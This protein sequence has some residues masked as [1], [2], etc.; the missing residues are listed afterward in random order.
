[1]DKMIYMDHGAT[2]PMSMKAFLAMR[3]FLVEEFG[4]PS[5]TYKIG[6][7]AKDAITEARKSVA[8]LIHADPS[9]IYFASGG[10][11]A[12]NWALIKVAEGMMTAGCGNH[13]ITSEIEHGAVLNTCKYLETIG[14]DVTYLPVNEEGLINPDELEN[15]INDKT[16]LVSIMYQNNEIGTI[17]P[18]KA[19]GEICNRH[20]IPFHT[21]AVQAV[22]HIPINVKKLHIDLLSASAHKLNGPKGVGFLYYNH[23]S[24]I[25]MNPLIM[26]GHQMDGLRAGTENV[27]GIVGFGEAAKLSAR[28]MRDNAKKCLELRSYLGEKLLTIPNSH[29]NGVDIFDKSKSW[30]RACN[31]IN[32][33]FDG[34]DSTHLQQL[35]SESNICVSVGS[36]CNSYS[37]E[38]SHVLKAI[39]LSDAEAFSTLRITLGYENTKEECDKVFNFIKTYVGLLR[40]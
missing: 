21:D 26:G 25:G 23:D 16:I 1:M 13:I 40:E 14:F 8:S 6:G 18:I 5:S 19:I 2:T 20:K 9:D 32:I 37:P 24:I 38:P 12:D 3:P 39:G 11:E 35:L 10:T 29:I 33:S 30:L 22:G 36:A 15:A 27:A 7:V 28:Y 34:I 31:N 4:N 17:E